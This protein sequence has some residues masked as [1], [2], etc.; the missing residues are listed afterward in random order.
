MTRRTPNVKSPLDN[1][2]AFVGYVTP[3]ESDDTMPLK[4]DTKPKANLEAVPGRRTQT[5]VRVTY[6]NVRMLNRALKDHSVLANIIN[7]ALTDYLTRN[8]YARKREG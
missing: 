5:S 6:E 2:A 4:I 8:G 1:T 7:A 3:V